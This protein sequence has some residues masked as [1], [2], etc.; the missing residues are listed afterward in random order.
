M[1]RR[2]TSSPAAVL[3][4]LVLGS[5]QGCGAT[6]TPS[7]APLRGDVPAVL[8]NNRPLQIPR[9]ELDRYTCAPGIRMVCDGAT[10]N[11]L[12]CNCP[13]VPVFP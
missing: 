13:S 4:V 11:Y 1:V 9:W 8:D 10:R 5:L 3:G 6:L 12:L 2:P 7:L